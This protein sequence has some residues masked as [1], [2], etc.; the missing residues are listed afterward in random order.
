MSRTHRTPCSSSVRIISRYGSLALQQ[1]VTTHQAQA[2]AQAHLRR[3]SISSE[4]TIYIDKTV[5]KEVT[6]EETKK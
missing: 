5:A 1:T 3:C 4:M 2:Q 6:Q